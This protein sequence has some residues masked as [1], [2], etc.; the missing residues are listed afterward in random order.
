MNDLVR[1]RVKPARD[2]DDA[3]VAVDARHGALHVTPAELGAQRVH[4][5]AD[6]AV[7]RK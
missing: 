3:R 6:N 7:K 5:H 4:A 2:L 1:S